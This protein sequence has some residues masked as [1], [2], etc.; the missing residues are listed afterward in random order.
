[1]IKGGPTGGWAD[2]YRMSD[3]TWTECASLW[4]F[5]WPSCTSRFSLAVGGG[6]KWTS[7]GLAG[8]W[9]TGT[10]TRP[11]SL[12]EEYPG[13]AGS[14]V[15]P[16]ARKVTAESRMRPSNHRTR[17]PMVTIITPHS[18]SHRSSPGPMT[19]GRADGRVARRQLPGKS[20]GRGCLLVSL[21]H[22]DLLRS[23]LPS[24]LP[25]K[26]RP[27]YLRCRPSPCP[28]PG[29]HVAIM[30]LATHSLTHSLIVHSR[31]SELGRGLKLNAAA[32]SVFTSTKRWTAKK[33]KK[34]NCSGWL[35]R[36]RVDS[37]HARTRRASAAAAAGRGGFG[38]GKERG[39]RRQRLE[40]R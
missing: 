40:K 37:A 34:R 17:T 35:P 18:H 7:S 15:N 9:S 27:N 21:S 31:R 29:C 24:R 23:T 11:T 20:W 30:S 10:S 38:E 19:G 4:Y 26:M 28:K 1:M 22:L 32:V 39:R 5:L 33:K 36:R 8:S 14:G 25:A 16:D 12:R 6:M 3:C 2:L 13:Y